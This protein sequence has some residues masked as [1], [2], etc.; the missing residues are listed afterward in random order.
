M[1]NTSPIF[2]DQSDII[3]SSNY[4]VRTDPFTGET[5]VFHRGTDFAVP[6]ETPIYALKSGNVTRSGYEDGFGKRISIRYDG[7]I[8]YDAFYGHLDSILISEGQ[9]VEVGQLIGYS[10]NTGKSSGPHLHY[11]EAYFVK[12]PE[13]EIGG[14]T[15]EFLKVTRDPAP[16]L[17]ASMGW[18][19]VPTSNVQIVYET[20]VGLGL[21]E[22]FKQNQELQKEISDSAAEKVDVIYYDENEESESYNISAKDQEATL[23]NSGLLAQNQQYT[24][25]D[26]NSISQQE[27]IFT[28]EDSNGN[29]NTIQKEGVMTTLKDGTK[30]LLSAVVEMTEVGVTNISNFFQ[31]KIMGI[32]Q[33]LFDEIFSSKEESKDENGDTAAQRL[34]GSI[35]AD[36]ILIYKVDKL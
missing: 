4:G 21:V 13:Y 35:L 19:E 25:K 6:I 36:I 14:D 27:A 11:E 29:I 5:G 12:N 30:A 1:S 2:K 22:L 3:I 34:A 32:F 10:G 23:K 16:N 15:S 20:P 24:D 18:L 31:S 26:G 28:V 8:K 7:D 17:N 33:P 9:Y